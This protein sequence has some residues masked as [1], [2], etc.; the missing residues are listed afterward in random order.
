MAKVKRVGI[1]EL[2]SKLSA[3]LRE[4]RSGTTVLVHDRDVCVAELRAP[5]GAYQNPVVQAWVSAGE[6]RPAY[7][8]KVPLKKSPVSTKRDLSR[9]LIDAERG[10]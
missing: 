7:G 5:E 4:V 3:Y 10:E 9:I 1:R 2:K 8:K 6:L